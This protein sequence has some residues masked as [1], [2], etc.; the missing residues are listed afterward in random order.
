MEADEA[1]LAGGPGHSTHLLQDLDQRGGPIQH[2]K[3]VLG[4][5]ICHS[6]RIHGTLSRQRIAQCTELGSGLMY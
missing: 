3:G 1:Y 2:E 5:L 4:D 6:Y